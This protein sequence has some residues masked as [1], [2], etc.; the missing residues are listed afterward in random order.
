M[1]SFLIQS[2]KRIKVMDDVELSKLLTDI[3]M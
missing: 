3:K 2:R 1:N